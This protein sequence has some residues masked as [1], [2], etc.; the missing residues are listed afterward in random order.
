MLKLFFWRKDS[1]NLMTHKNGLRA[2]DIAALQNLKVGDR[3]ILW[4]NQAASPDQTNYYTLKVFQSRVVGDSTT[5]SVSGE[6]VGE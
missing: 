4:E 3:L 6:A 5:V 1:G 2:E